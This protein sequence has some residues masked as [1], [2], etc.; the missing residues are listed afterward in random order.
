M[1][2]DKRFPINLGCFKSEAEVKVSW[3]SSS[4]FGNGNLM[5]QKDED[6]VMQG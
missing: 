2:L 1:D 3:N 5:V 6:S 4:Q